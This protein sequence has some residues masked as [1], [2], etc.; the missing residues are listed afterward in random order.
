TGVWRWQ[1]RANFRSGAGTVSGGYSPPVAFT[2]HI[3][4]PTGL[5]TTRSGSGA[6]L[7]WQPAP[8]ARQY[9][10]QISATDTFTT[11]ADPA[12]VD[13]SSFA[14]RMTQPAIADAERLYWRVAVVDEGG[15]T[16]GWAM[17]PL[18]SPLALR[19]KVSGSLRR[20][21]T[22][23]LRVKVTDPRGRAL[24]GAAVKA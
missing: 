18:R 21:R 16:G 3:A 19:V 13:G 7:S 11:L 22:G 4:T 2:R 24:K 10:V 6:L 5:K 1:V 14:P 17:T 23:T 20:G 9:R 12:P 15:S 8:M